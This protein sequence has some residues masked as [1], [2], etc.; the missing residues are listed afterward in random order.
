MVSKHNPGMPRL[1]R[2]VMERKDQDAETKITPLDSMCKGVQVESIEDSIRKA[3][4]GIVQKR[5][6]VCWYYQGP[7][8]FVR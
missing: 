8:C 4:E 5:K 1:H 2:V 6:E 7:F 3:F